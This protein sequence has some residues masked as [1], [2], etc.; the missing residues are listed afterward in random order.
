VVW[1]AQVLGLRSEAA[2]RRARSTIGCDSGRTA[3]SS[4][5]ADERPLY[6]ESRRTCRAGS[7]GRNGSCA[8][9]RATFAPI[10][11]EFAT[12]GQIQPFASTLRQTLGQALRTDNELSL[13]GL[14]RDV[15][16]SSH[17]K[18]QMFRVADVCARLRDLGQSLTPAEQ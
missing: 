14:G 17:M 18:R 10:A 2:I 8:A 11:Y 15:G 4:M 9:I 3:A 1:V 7:T 12:I 13:L 5:R 16:R 6:V